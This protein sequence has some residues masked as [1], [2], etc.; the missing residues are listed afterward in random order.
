MPQQALALANSE[1]A[2]K[3][4]RALAAAVGK[5]AGDN[6]DDFIQAAF[7]RVLGRRAKLAEAQTLP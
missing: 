3:Q 7:L 1:I 5:E 6:D 4:A 2:F